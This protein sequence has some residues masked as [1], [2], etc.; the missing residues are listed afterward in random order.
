MDPVVEADELD[1]AVEHGVG[2]GDDLL[3]TG[4]LADPVV[5]DVPDRPQGARPEAQRHPHVDARGRLS[6]PQH[7]RR[8]DHVALT[9]HDHGSHPL[10]SGLRTPPVALSEASKKS[11]R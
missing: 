3:G 10:S 4:P 2:L 1:A 8:E 7:E 9:F 11:S 5:V 6:T